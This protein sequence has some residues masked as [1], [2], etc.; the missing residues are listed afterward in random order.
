MLL[1]WRVFYNSIQNKKLHMDAARSLTT[2]F[3]LVFRYFKEVEVHFINITERRSRVIN[4]PDSYSEGL[5]F[6]SRAEDSYSNWSFRGFPQFS[7]RI[8]ITFVF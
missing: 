3:T 4:I 5:G 1:L 7:L 2:L 8:T 6:K